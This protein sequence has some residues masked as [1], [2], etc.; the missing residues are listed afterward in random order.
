[1]KL[2]FYY[3][4]TIQK[5]LS[6]ENNYTVGKMVFLW[7]EKLQQMYALNLFLRSLCW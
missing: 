2:T 6:Q 7:T 4:F 1:M 3:P 5:K